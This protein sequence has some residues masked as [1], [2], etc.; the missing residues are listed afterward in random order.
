[1]LDMFN[2]LKEGLRQ[3]RQK[4]STCEI[5]ANKIVHFSFFNKT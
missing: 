5:N 1:M 2:G 3:D 4:H